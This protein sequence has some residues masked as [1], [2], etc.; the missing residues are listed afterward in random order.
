MRTDPKLK[1]IGNKDESYKKNNIEER[2]HLGLY[3]VW[4]FGDKVEFFLV[5]IEGYC[6]SSMTCKVLQKRLHKTTVLQF[7]T[8]FAFFLW[9]LVY[10]IETL[11]Q[12]CMLRISEIK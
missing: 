2:T 3:A 7:Q 12:V 10:S 4:H 9:N 11:A 8:W 1:E 6:G 5:W